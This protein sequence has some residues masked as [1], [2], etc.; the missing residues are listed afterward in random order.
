MVNDCKHS[1]FCSA[2]EERQHVPT[3]KID[4]AYKYFRYI[5]T[6]Y[7]YFQCSRNASSKLG[8][9]FNIICSAE[10]SLI[11]K[12]SCHHNVL[13]LREV[14][15]RRKVIADGIHTLLLIARPLQSTAGCTAEIASLRSVVGENL[16][17]QRNRERGRP[18]QQEYKSREQG[19]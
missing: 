18:S 1:A 16:S 11:M 14:R 12:A 10:C 13:C 3:Y 19:T 5:H 4:N 6:A 17:L 15:I 8:T 9:Y 7:M 2:E